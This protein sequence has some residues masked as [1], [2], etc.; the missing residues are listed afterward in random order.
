MPR[1]YKP[2]IDAPD[3]DTP[4]PGQGYGDRKRQVQQMDAVPPQNRR[5]AVSQAAQ[6]MN[7]QTV[8]LGG[9]PRGE[10]TAVP[11]TAGAPFG[12]GPGPRSAQVRQLTGRPVGQARVLHDMLPLIERLASREGASAATR[13][14]VRKLRGELLS[15]RSGMGG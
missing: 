12:P 13:R 14:L 7:F 15:T 4:V 1:D 11:S 6:N 8:G 5:E 2:K 9:P 3:A 10:E